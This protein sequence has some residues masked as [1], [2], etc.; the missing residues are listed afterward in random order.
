M[1][2]RNEESIRV[3]KLTART[4]GSFLCATASL[5]DESMTTAVVYSPDSNYNPRVSFTVTQCELHAGRIEHN[6]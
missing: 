2:H 4:V 6:Y 3:D 5:Y 1:L